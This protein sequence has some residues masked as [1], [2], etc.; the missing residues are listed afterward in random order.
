[1]ALKAIASRHDVWVLGHGKDSEAMARARDEGLIG[2]N[3]RF[4]PHRAWGG[5]HANRI[6][7]RM[8]NWRDYQIWSRDVL[9]TAKRLEKEVGF[10]VVH[11]VTLSTWRVPS[12]L[13]R[14]GKPFV[15]GPVG[16]G[17]V[18][19]MRLLAGA[20]LVPAC[21]ELLRRF[22]D[23]RALQSRNLAEC[24]K[25]SAF[26]FAST[27]ETLRLLEAAGCPMG[28]IKLL[29]AAFFD[30]AQVELLE[31][32]QKFVS[33]SSKRSLKLFAGGDIEARKGYHI[34]LKALAEARRSG[35]DFEYR[36]A[37]GGPQVGALKNLAKSLGIDDL[38]RISNPFSGEQYRRALW[39][40][41][42]YFLPS[43]RDN[44]PVTLMEAM[45]AGCVPIVAD[46]GGPGMIVDGDSGFKVEV[47]A[48]KI[49]VA[50]FADRLV[51]LGFSLKSLTKISLRARKRIERGFSEKNYLSKVEE[52]YSALR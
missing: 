50:G 17:E 8:Q 37:G 40:S 23:G 52:V 35:L 33:D 43:L 16:G 12:E 19:P 46:C 15:W 28:K 14:I 6:V 38:V 47:C 9:K 18:F 11:H 49:M 48:E 24:L 10:D 39:E 7:A 20:G 34:A 41:D 2:E 45:V 44:A 30:S 26:I 13:W 4:F 31:R 51:E 29:S 36:I 21:Y 27:P 3:V 5:R 32:P 25:K 22:H 1:M 42:I